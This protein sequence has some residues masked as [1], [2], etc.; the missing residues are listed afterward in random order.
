MRVGEPSGRLKEK[1]CK[2]S[3]RNDIHIIYADGNAT[4]ITWKPKEEPILE[5]R[6][7]G[8]LFLRIPFKET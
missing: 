3:A 4:D 2:P 1:Y 7:E 5:D 6:F 8:D